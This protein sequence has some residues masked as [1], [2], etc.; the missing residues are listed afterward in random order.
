MLFRSILANTKP[1]LEKGCS[2]L[3]VEV[4]D[5]RVGAGIF[6]GIHMDE[7]GHKL[8]ADALIS[9]IKEL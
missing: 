7:K 4:I 8:V 2:G 1:Y 6:D 9:V 5:T 3:N